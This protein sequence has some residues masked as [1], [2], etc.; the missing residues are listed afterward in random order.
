MTWLTVSENSVK[1]GMAEQGSP[2]Q[3]EI[4]AACLN[5]FFTYLEAKNGTRSPMGNP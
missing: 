2:G 5:I 4:E 3:Q 1:K